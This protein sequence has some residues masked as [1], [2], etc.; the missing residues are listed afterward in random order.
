MLVE[1]ISINYLHSAVFMF[2]SSNQDWIKS[3]IL[4]FEMSHVTL[5]YQMLDRERKDVFY[6][7]CLWFHLAPFFKPFIPLLG[8]RIML[9]LMVQEILVQFPTE[10]RYLDHRSSFKK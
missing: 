10:R 1:C 6:E 5:L 8:S 2:V 3:E 7:L 4:T 9:G